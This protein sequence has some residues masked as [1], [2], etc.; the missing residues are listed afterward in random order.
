MWSCGWHP[1]FGN[2][3]SCQR[4][5]WAKA[6]SALFAVIVSR[7]IPFRCIDVNKSTALDHRLAFPYA[8]ITFPYITLSERTEC[9]R[10]RS[11]RL[12]ALDYW[13]AFSHAPM[14]TL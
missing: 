7:G 9:L 5:L 12:K 8:H 6:P 4:E 11:N 13:L 2:A 1:G 14:A 3:P 10:M